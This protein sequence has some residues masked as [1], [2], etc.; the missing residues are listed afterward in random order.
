MNQSKHLS[1]ET[2]WNLPSSPGNLGILIWMFVTYSPSHTYTHMSECDRYFGRNRHA[3]SPLS[4]LLA[5]ISFTFFCFLKV[6]LVVDIAMLFLCCWLYIFFNILFAS[7]ILDFWVDRHDKHAYVLMYLQTYL[8]TYI[9]RN[10]KYFLCEL[11]L[12]FL[13]LCSLCKSVNIWLLILHSVN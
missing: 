12:N 2:L 1:F 10:L 13:H 4:I 8:S 3:L 11:I 7:P 5:F 6:L 9:Q